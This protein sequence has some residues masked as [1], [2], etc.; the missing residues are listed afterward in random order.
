MI[1]KLNAVFHLLTT[2]FQ[3]VVDGNEQVEHQ[4][5]CIYLF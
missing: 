1:L 3:I 2:F 5:T 4:Y